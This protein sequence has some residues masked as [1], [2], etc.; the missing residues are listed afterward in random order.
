MVTQTAAAPAQTATGKRVETG[1]HGRLPVSHT[2]RPARDS[3]GV[4]AGGSVGISQNSSISQAGSGSAETATGQT[5]P[6]SD[7]QGARNGDSERT[8]Q[9]E[10]AVNSAETM[11]KPTHEVPI[12]WTNPPEGV[13]AKNGFS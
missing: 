10:L 12:Y 3:H 1:N 2:N 7:S 4:T 6:G 9:K 5:E 13:S 8:H 11:P